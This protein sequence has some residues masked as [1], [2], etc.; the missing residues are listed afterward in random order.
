MQVYYTPQKSFEDTI[1]R[2]IQVILS[3]TEIF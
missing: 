1:F 3:N 2:V